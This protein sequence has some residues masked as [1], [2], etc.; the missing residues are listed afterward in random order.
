MRPICDHHTDGGRRMP[1]PVPVPKPSLP[2]SRLEGLNII[3]WTNVPVRD[4]FA[5][6]MISLY[7]DTDHSLLGAFEPELFVRD[8][9]SH[10]GVY[11]SSLLVNAMMYWASV[12]AHICEGLIFTEEIS[13]MEHIANVQ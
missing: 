13:L 7:L 4:E 9:I 12:S 11:C 1:R 8:L 10:E 2:D 5:S 6:K 3:F